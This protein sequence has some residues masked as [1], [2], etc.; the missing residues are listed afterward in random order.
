MPETYDFY[1]NPP[2]TR[3]AI[4]EY[5]TSWLQPVTEREPKIINGRSFIQVNGFRRAFYIH[6]VWRCVEDGHYY[7][8]VAPDDRCDFADFPTKSYASYEALMDAVVED[9]YNR[10]VA[11]DYPTK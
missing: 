7:W 6:S 2:Q 11:T 5:Y 4:R 8:Y 1:A 3:E 9:Y 10:W